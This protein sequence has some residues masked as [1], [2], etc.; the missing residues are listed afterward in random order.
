MSKRIRFN[1]GDKVELPIMSPAPAGS[2][3]DFEAMA[4][5]AK[6]GRAAACQAKIDAALKEHNCR[7]NVVQIYLNGQMRDMQISLVALDA[8]PQ[9]PAPNGKVA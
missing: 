1:R 9:L 3:V 5:A 2:S 6:A 7:I 8:Q 4:A